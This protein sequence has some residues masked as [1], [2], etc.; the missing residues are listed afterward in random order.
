MAERESDRTP[1]NARVL[2]K[3]LDPSVGAFSLSGW[4]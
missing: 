3:K 4:V 1:E 2:A